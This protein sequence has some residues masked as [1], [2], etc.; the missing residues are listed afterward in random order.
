MLAQSRK[1]STYARH[2]STQQEGKQ[3]FKRLKVWEGDG[4]RQ[5][6]KHQV[7][8]VHLGRKVFSES[9]KENTFAVQDQSVKLQLL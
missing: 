7:Y 2:R 9:K 6:E 4:G 5:V 1:N 3:R 8:V